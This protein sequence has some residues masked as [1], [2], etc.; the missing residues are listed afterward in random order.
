DGS[1]VCWGANDDGQLGNGTTANSAIPLQVVGLDSSE[2]VLI[3]SGG[4]CTCATLA[5]GTTMCWGG[6][7]NGQL[8]NGTVINSAPPYGSTIPVAVKW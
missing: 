4:S 3:G 5:S 1:V 7:W 8:G 6:D 2:A